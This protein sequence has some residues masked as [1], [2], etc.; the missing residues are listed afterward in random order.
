MSS[1]AAVRETLIPGIQ[2]G[3]KVELGAQGHI[4]DIYVAVR[5]VV[6]DAGCLYCQPGLI[7]PIRLQQEARN[8]EEARAQNYLDASEVIDPSVISLNGIGASHAVNTMLLSVT[9]LS[10]GPAAQQLFFVRDGAVL[11]V[12]LRPDPHCPFCGRHE[13]S[14]FA[15]GGPVGELPVRRGGPGARTRSSRGNAKLQRLRAFLRR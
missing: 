7:D 5:P 3:A 10:N 12:E 2:I 8:D 6:P 13:H 9:G 4:D 1:L 15:K 11:S 14:V